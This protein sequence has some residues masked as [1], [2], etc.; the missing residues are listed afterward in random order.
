VTADDMRI[1]F[2]A[3]AKVWRKVGKMF[4]FVSSEKHR[5]KHAKK[6]RSQAKNCQNTFFY[7]RTRKEQVSNMFKSL[8]LFS[9]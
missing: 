3:V 2:S 6:R 9:H 7:E 4:I 8:H 1:N 5:H